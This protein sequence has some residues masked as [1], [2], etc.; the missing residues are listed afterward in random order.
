LYKTDPL[1]VVSAEIDED[2][3]QVFFDERGGKF[4]LIYRDKGHR[5]LPLYNFH[6][7]SITEEHKSITLKE[8]GVML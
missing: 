7:F 8:M 4:A 3:D 2:V 5:A 1:E 6:F